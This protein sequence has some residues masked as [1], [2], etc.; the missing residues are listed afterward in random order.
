[1]V[2]YNVYFSRTPD[3]S[4]EQVGIT[5]GNSTTFDHRK[6]PSD[7]FAGCYYVTAV[8]ILDAESQPSNI[9]CA[10]NCNKIA[11]P[12]IFSP[13]GDGKNDTFE[14][15]DC[16]AF[17]KSISYEIYN[18]YGLLVAN[19]EG[20]SLSWNGIGINGSVMPVGT[21]YYLIKVQFNRL[22]E[23]SEVFTYKGYLEL[24]N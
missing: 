24:V 7:G 2:R 20:T 19:G 22:E 3:G 18:R 10:D 11:F 16:P 14:P 6:N 12:N 9:I 23:N 17:I 21:Y 5:E 1:L 15:M 13:N 4:F 8:S